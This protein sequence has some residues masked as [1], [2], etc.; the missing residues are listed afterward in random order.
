MRDCASV[1]H[2]V[3]LDC[4]IHHSTFTMAIQPL[5]LSCKLFIHPTVI[6]STINSNSSMLRALQQ[7]TRKSGEDSADES[8]IRPDS[9]HTTAR[10]HLY[11]RHWKNEGRRLHLHS[12]VK[13]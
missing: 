10:K 4:V 6:L 7:S 1:V 12:T 8:L 11:I 3:H 13:P 2:A 9:L 5:S